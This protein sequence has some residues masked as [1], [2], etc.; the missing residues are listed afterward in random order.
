MQAL[1]RIQRNFTKFALHFVDFFY[2]ERCSLYNILPLCPRRE[3][4]DLKLLFKSMYVPTFCDGIAN[5]VK[6][7]VPSARLRSNLHIYHSLGHFC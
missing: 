5:T 2:K 7:A 6:P 4:C 1:D 3:I